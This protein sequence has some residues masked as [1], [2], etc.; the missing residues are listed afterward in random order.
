MVVRAGDQAVHSDHDD[1]IVSR[2]VEPRNPVAQ[3]VAFIEPQR[4]CNIGETILAD[5]ERKGTRIGR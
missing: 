1:Q 3:V 4:S 2:T 5:A